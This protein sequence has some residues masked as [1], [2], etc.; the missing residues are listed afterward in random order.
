MSHEL[1]VYDDDAAFVDAMPPFLAAGVEA[2]EAVVAVL[3]SRSNELVRDALGS[4]G[5]EVT[6]I[7]AENHYTR[8]EAAL[9]DY[10]ASVRRYLRDGAPAVRLCGEL[11]MCSTQQQWDEW[12]AYEAIL[13]RAFAH[14]PVSIMCV[15]DERRMPASVV[16][17]A[18]RC[19][20][21]LAGG[22]ARA[23]NPDYEDPASVVSDMWPSAAESSGDL[24]ELVLDNGA[25]SFRERLTAAMARA[26]VADGSA[27]GML[28]AADEVL[29]NAIRHGG[30]V[31]G[32][33]AGRVGDEFLCE[34]SADGRWH[35]DPL[36]GFLPPRPDAVAGGGLWVA[37]QLTRRLELLPSPSVGLLARLWV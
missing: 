34:I 17:G 4:T 19:H 26:G 16:D 36:A 35:D 28:V 33:H 21:D 29:S 18:R 27:R 7:A 12:V 11:P 14:H 1:F 24:Q 37:R 2:G 9:A 20:P 6:F 22:H 15:Y 31:Q 30:G 10:D 25:V 3:A 5:R 32:V 23:S 8:P 13:N